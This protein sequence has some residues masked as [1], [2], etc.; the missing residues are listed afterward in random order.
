[1]LGGQRPMLQSTA[2]PVG[3]RHCPLLC[4]RSREDCLLRNEGFFFYSIYL[5]LQNLMDEMQETKITLPF[6]ILL[7]MGVF[8]DYVF[9]ELM[10]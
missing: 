4:A 2:I 8:V 3:C 9:Y 6:Q 1:M 5:I 7:Y 10:V